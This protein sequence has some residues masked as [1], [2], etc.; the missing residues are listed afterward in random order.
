LRFLR[1]LRACFATCIVAIQFAPV[2]A[3]DTRDVAARLLAALPDVPHWI[4]TRAMLRSPHVQLFAGPSFDEGV[5]VRLLHGAMVAVSAIGR[6]HA[7]ALA[8]ALAGITPMTPIVAQE[9]N[10]D[11]VAQLLKEIGPAHGGLQWSAEP[12]R[13][14]TLAAAPPLPLLEPGAS[15]RL[16]T[17]SD[18]LDHLPSGLRHEITHARIDYPT[19][20]AFVGGVPVSFCY[21]CFASES[22][23]DVSIDTLEEYRRRGLAAHVV[24]FMIDRMRDD[25]LEPI[26]GALESNGTSLRLAAR[27]GF[28]TPVQGNI[29]FSRGPWAYLTGGYNF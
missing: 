24:R 9:D 14:H 3:I 25:R 16:L 5:V 12:M 19:G 7:T 17:P 29:V 28:T 21:G 20:A 2:A 27:L 15:I 4:E 22:L 13:F 23:W 26:W 10:A 6:P 11:H 18:A 8:S 1:G